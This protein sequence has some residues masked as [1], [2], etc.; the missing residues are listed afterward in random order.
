MECDAYA[1]LDD[2]GEVQLILQHT[3]DVTDL[4]EAHEILADRRRESGVLQRARRV[5]QANYTLDTERRHLRRLFEQAPGFVA[6]LTGPTHVFDLVNAAYRDLIGHRDVV[7]KPV[8]EALPEVADQGFVRVLDEVFATARPFIGRGL[9]VR[10]G[11]QVGGA[12]EEVFVDFIFQPIVDDTGAVTGI[13]VQGHDISAQKRLEAERETLLEQQRFLTEAIPQ[14]VWTADSAGALTS[15]NARAME[16]F[17]VS[18]DRV[19][20]SGWQQFVHPE[21]LE[22]AL[23]RWRASLSSGSDYEVEFRLR[24]A[25]GT[26]R[27]HL[28]RAVAMRD[29]SGEVVRWLGTNTI[30]RFFQPFERGDATVSAERSV[31][32]G[33]FIS[34]QIVEAH[35]GTIGVQSTAQHGAIFRVRLPRAAGSTVAA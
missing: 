23:D 28:G 27:W 30:A 29:A 31:G 11:R 17:G 16:Y 3:V 8:R 21:D 9:P 1:H 2:G 12:L 33:L 25:D 7:G 34:K 22:K 35:E 32:L 14:Q 18:V 6:V 5:Q 19:L 24:R 26:Y 15:A 10:L 4:H 20:G 13:F